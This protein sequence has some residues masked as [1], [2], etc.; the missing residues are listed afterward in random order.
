MGEYS[1]GRKFYYRMA[2]PRYHTMIVHSN[3]LVFHETTKRTISKIGY[4]FCPVGPGGKNVEACRAYMQ[5]LT[6]RILAHS[7]SERNR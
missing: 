4:C 2:T 5:K 6:E 7:S 1:S 3:F